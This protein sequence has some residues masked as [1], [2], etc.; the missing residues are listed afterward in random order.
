VTSLKRTARP[1]AAIAGMALAVLL[2]GSVFAQGAP[3]G[4]II[5]AGLDA[6]RGLQ[7]LDDGSLLVA[8]GGGRVITIAPDGTIDVVASGLPS[9][10]FDDPPLGT[11]TIG[12]SSAL[13]V[14]GGAYVVLVG[15]GPGPA[16]QSLYLVENGVAAKFRDMQA[17]ENANNHD[18]DVD[19]DGNPELLSNPFDVTSDG[20]GGMYFTDSGANTVF[21]LSEDGTLTAFAIFLNRT[22]PL[23]DV[24]GGPTMDQ[25]PTGITLGPDGAVY[26]TTLTGFPFPPGGGRIYR[27]EDGN[28]DGD[29]LDEGETT[30]VFEGITMATDLAFEPNGSILVTQFSLN[31]LQEL[32][33]SLVRI[34]P[35]G[36]MTTV[37]DGLITPTA[38]AVGANGEIYVSQEF[39]GIVSE[40]SGAGQLPAPGPSDTG[41]AGLDASAS[42]GLALLIAALATL[43]FVGSSRLLALRPRRNER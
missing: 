31:A 29:A 22:N 1:F 19:I 11:V 41:N 9:A 30:I 2:L 20:A 3:P 17:V 43:M 34:A 13:S 10:S 5:A 24:V 23:A 6:P 16:F 12:P 40:V 25:V 7:V 42:S 8:E 4:T 39:A 14:G 18:A 37:V 36:T 26:I 38:V 33:G 21:H 32:P 15:E 28:G 27:M 35:N